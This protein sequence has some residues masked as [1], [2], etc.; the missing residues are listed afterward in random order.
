MEMNDQLTHDLLQVYDEY[1]LIFQ[2]FTDVQINQIPFEGSW[3]PGQVA[4]HIIKSTKRIPDRDTAPPERAFD[5]KV[6]S[7]ES[8]F[9]D[10]ENK[11]KAPEYVEPGGGPFERS[12]ILSQFDE[13]K[14]R[15]KAALADVDLT[16]LC[17]NF[18]LPVVGTMTRYEWYRFFVIHGQRHLYQLRNIIKVINN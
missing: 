1:I 12:V 14:V 15:H 17:L 7:I 2:N 8:V 5:A 13:L 3:T 4:D 6:A 9:L 10:F 16:Q 11:R 18:E